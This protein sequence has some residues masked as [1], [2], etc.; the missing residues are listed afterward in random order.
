MN[1]TYTDQRQQNSPRL[2]CAHGHK[3]FLLF[4]K[5]PNPSTTSGHNMQVR[6]HFVHAAGT[7]QEDCNVLP[8]KLSIWHAGQGQGDNLPKYI[9]HELVRTFFAPDLTKYIVIILCHC[10]IS[11]SYFNG[12]A[13]DLARG[14]QCY[15][16]KA[17]FPLDLH[18]QTPSLQIQVRKTD[19]FA[20]TVPG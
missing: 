1:L 3:I 8:Y 15:M 5:A 19:T 7:G 9:L 12:T 6:K 13:L 10:P 20:V 18:T 4:R 14:K 11:S 2:S 17:E 16:R